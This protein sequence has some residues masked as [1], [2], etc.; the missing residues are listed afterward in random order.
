MSASDRRHN[1]FQIFRGVQRRIRFKVRKAGDPLAP[2]NLT[3]C[4]ATCSQ[5][6]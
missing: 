3:G 5:E 1:G 4:S 2:F 6:C